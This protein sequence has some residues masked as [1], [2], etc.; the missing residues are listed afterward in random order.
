MSGFSLIKMQRLLFLVPRRLPQIL[1]VVFDFMYIFI[2]M[3][4]AYIKLKIFIKI[5]LWSYWIYKLLDI[6]S[7]TKKS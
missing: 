6:I 7:D 1:T 2:F 3:F 5:V 4:S